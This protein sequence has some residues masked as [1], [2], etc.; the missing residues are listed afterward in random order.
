MQ[1]RHSFVVAVV[2]LAGMATYASTTPVKAAPAGVQTA[3]AKVSDR[4]TAIRGGQTAAGP[5]P[6]QKPLGPE[7]RKRLQDEALVQLQSTDLSTLSQAIATLRALQG[8]DAAR[9]LMERLRKGLPPQFA[10]A[11]V[12][13]LGSMN[14]PLVTPVLI[15]LTLHRRWQIR[16]KA[17]VALGALKMRT[18]VS[19]LLYALDDPS[20]EV[21]SAAALA[22][23]QL[24]DPRA[25]PALAAALE[26]GVSGALPALAQLGNARHV[27]LILKYA[28][29]N[30]QA[31]EPSLRIVLTRPNLHISSKLTVLKTIQGLA[32]PEAQAMLAS[33]RSQLGK[34]TDP[35]LLAAL[36]AP[37]Q[38]P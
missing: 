13:A 19:A 15:E 3:V 37:V 31:S 35:Q 11:A 34:G 29:Q 2:A 17:V 12:D 38:K 26:H 16:E 23:G 7:E 1:A 22:L 18:A 30:L 20:A 33:W 8:R 5:Q 6:E 10:E 4:G 25:L 28:V 14:Q 21:R 36:R 27:E 32:Q 24:S 9:A